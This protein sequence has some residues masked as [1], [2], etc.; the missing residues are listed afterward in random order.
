MDKKTQL[1]ASECPSNKWGP[2]L[3]PDA[4]K[5]Q[6]EP[7]VNTRRPLMRTIDLTTYGESDRTEITRLAEESLSQYDGRF[8]HNGVQ[9]LV[10]ELG[11]ET[12]RKTVIYRMLPKGERRGIVDN[13]SATERAELNSLARNTLVQSNNVPAVFSFKDAQFKVHPLVGNMRGIRIE[14]V[15]EQAS[16]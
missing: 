10:K 11:P 8:M 14:L 7:A 16:T 15:S 5:K 2:E 12:D 1:D 9:Y 4:S 6:L 13:L 3:R